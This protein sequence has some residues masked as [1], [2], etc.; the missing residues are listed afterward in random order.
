MTDRTRP[1]MDDTALAAAL[2]D[3]ATA[4]DWPVAAATPGSPDIA[5][6]VRA[7]IGEARPVARP[8]WRPARRAL[9]LALAALLVLAAIA[10]AVGLGLPGL[11]ITLGP[12][13]TSPPG[14]SPA[15][16]ASPGATGGPSGT[17][18]VPGSGLGLGAPTTLADAAS[19]VGHPIALPSDPTLGP[20]DAVWID[21]L[22]ADQVA[23]VWRTRP[24]LPATLEPGIGLILMSFDGTMDQGYFEKVINSGTSMERVQVAG[25]QGFWITGRPHFFFYVQADGNAVDDSRR[26]VGNALIWSD[27]T[28]THRLEG[29]LDRE[30]MVRIAESLH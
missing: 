12:A 30:S 1:P 10:G 22:H 11:R 13:P 23:L 8:W 24:D 29:S 4:I 5:A 3:L 7:R 2:R 6:R 21:P 18:A 15:L 16:S 27:G 19:T 17:I 28:I 9:V 20:P 26:W 14:A 25:Q